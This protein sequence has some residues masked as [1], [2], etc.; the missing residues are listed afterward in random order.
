MKWKFFVWHCKNERTKKACIM[1]CIQQYQWW[2]ATA[3]CEVDT[4]NDTVL[5]VRPALSL[6][7]ISASH[8]SA[9]MIHSSPADHQSSFSCSDNNNT[10]Q[11]RQVLVSRQL[12]IALR[13]S[14]SR[15]RQWWG[16][17]SIWGW[18]TV[19]SAGNHRVDVWPTFL[20]RSRSQALLSVVCIECCAGGWWCLR[21][22]N[23]FVMTSRLS[24]WLEDIIS[25]SRESFQLQPTQ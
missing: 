21:H 17:E 16:G 9:H 23:M 12:L 25:E 6:T 13:A 22:N 24:H 20:L 3:N 18:Q 14:C 5:E 2:P 19:L 10:D 11:R 8:I 4:R 15:I 7:Q 1:Q